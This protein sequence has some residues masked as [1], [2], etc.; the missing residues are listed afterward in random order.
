M[1]FIRNVTIDEWCALLFIFPSVYKKVGFI[2]GA[3][4]TGAHHLAVISEFRFFSR[5]SRF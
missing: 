4:L 2:F 3:G 1:L 5:V